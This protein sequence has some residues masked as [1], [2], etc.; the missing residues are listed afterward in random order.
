[1]SVLGEVSPVEA[2]LSAVIRVAV[3]QHLIRHC[4]HPGN[5]YVTNPVCEVG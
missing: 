5:Y 3:A 2:A 1:M 4:F